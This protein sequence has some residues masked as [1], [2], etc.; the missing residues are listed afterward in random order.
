MRLKQN[1][2]TDTIVKARA[3]LMG[4]SKLD[5][6]SV[7][8]VAAMCFL[9]LGIIS[10]IL[11]TTK[12]V[13][14][15]IP[16]N[17]SGTYS[18]EASVSPN[19]IYGTSKLITGNPVL[20]SAVPNLYIGFKY[21]LSST[22]TTS[23][24]GTEQLVMSIQESGITRALPLQDAPVQFSGNTVSAI[25]TLNTAKLQS[26]AN[27]LN[28]AFG[29][30]SGSQITVQ[31]F[32]NI[33]ETG[34]IGGRGVNS[35]FN[36]PLSFGLSSSVLQLANP[37]SSS[38]I[39]GASSPT[40]QLSDSSQG[41]VTYPATV[42]AV[43]PFGIVHP[44]VVAGRMIAL[45]GLI[46]CAIIGGFILWSL[47]RSED[48]EPLMIDARYGPR[49]IRVGQIAF[50]GSAIVSVESISVLVTIANKYNVKVLHS[51]EEGNDRYAVLDNGVLYLYQPPAPNDL[52]SLVQMEEDRLGTTEVVLDGLAAK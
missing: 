10:L 2:K 34:T 43:L 9:A 46:A 15:K 17:Q 36:P 51:V 18:Y 7:T 23:L 22:Q 28:T 37:P 45:V 21:Q 44:G 14:A 11:P 32:P 38:A 26:I 27:A 42:S 8:A 35:S 48:D 31:V 12:V 30:I 25:G 49:L 16:Y 24:E 39:V 6:L 41:S 13:Q 52:G 5:I 40:A 3:G 29:G 50:Q 33:K 47:R 4:L 20:L 1:K 19:S